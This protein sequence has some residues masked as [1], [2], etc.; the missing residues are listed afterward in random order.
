V[1][2]G[3]ETGSVKKKPHINP[4]NFYTGQVSVF[5][6][7]ENLKNGHT[8]FPKGMGETKRR[9]KKETHPR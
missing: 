6:I 9:V 5:A 2:Q 8:R 7:A 3:Q 4:I 1:L